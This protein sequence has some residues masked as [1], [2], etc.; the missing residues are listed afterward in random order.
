M[1][2][3]NSELVLPHIYPVAC[4]TDNVGPGSVFVAIRGA[5]Q[6]GENY[7]TDAVEKGASAIV[8]DENSEL[9]PDVLVFV[10]EKGIKISRV[11]NTRKALAELSSSVLGCPSSKLSVIGVTGTKGKTT[12]VYVIEHLL[13]CAG[14]KTALL[15]T[16]E[17]KIG[18]MAC[19]ASLTT[20]Q[21]DYLHVFFNECVKQNVDYVVMEVAAQ[22]LSLHRTDG[23]LFDSVL[24]TN[25]SLE[26]SEFYS[27]I[28][29]YFKA[30]ALLFKQ[31][32]NPEFVFVNCD[33]EHGR[34]V[35]KKN[36]SYCS[37]S[38]KDK[39]SVFCADVHE[40]SLKKLS[41]SIFDKGECFNI[42]SFSLVGEFN[43][44]NILGAYCVVRS[45]GVFPKKLVKACESLPSVS[46][47]LEKYKLPNGAH[48]F[49]D[50]AH[51]PSSYEAVLSTMRS[52]SSHLI[53]VFGAGGSRD[54]TKRPQMGKIASQYADVVVL[55]SDNPRTE[56][57]SNI[58]N[59]I[60]K[61]I[62]RENIN[63][64]FVELDREK[65]IY[66]AYEFS[67]NESTIML[68]GK[69]PDEYQ[70]IKGVKSFF[71]DSGV[72]KSIVW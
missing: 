27:S 64:V 20:Q 61:G 2:C 30:K 4:H 37:F 46:G 22:A 36:L 47:R 3:K 51:N 6:N 38:L 69:G 63:K 54:V 65:A 29:E 40:S 33:D 19:R 21:P 12:S 56:D 15:S 39:S 59:D 53:V 70:I 68:L 49:V 14:Y 17:N 60:V 41:M 18:T 13:R 52:F 8:M 43:A 5:E 57:P 55:T 25:L 58:I 9:L 1:Y 11:S 48:C 28:E 26:H 31:V 62:D 10:K 23:I 42:E 35:L 44:Y 71:S 72:V 7:I 24:F 67:G 16:V 34:E 66:K 32:K 50:Y 45:L